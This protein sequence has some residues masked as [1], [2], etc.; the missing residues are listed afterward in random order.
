M[1]VVL[2]VTVNTRL[3]SKE[4]LDAFGDKVLRI[5]R[6][7]HQRM[8]KLNYPPSLAVSRPVRFQVQP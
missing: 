5:L 1:G 2:M 3:G 4:Q 7:A 6:D 8:D